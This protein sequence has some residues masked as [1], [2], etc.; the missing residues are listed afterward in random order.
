MS[1]LT[2]MFATVFTFDALSD[3]AKAFFLLCSIVKFFGQSFN[4]KKASFF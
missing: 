3:L 2:T 1:I 4:L